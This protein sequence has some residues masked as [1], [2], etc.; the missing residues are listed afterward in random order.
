[1]GIGTR[2]EAT[3]QYIHSEGLAKGHW[4]IDGEGFL[5]IVPDDRY[6]IEECAG[7]DNATM[8]ALNALYRENA[9]DSVVPSEVATQLELD[10]VPDVLRRFD[11][12][13]GFYSA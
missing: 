3:Q 10:F 2:D 7:P 5:Y 8:D 9:F 11:E 12:E 1:M 6:G 13:S 4:Y